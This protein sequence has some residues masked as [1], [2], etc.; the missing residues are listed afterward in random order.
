[1]LVESTDTLHCSAAAATTA[2]AP[3]ADDLPQSATAA[4][5][6]IGQSTADM[7]ACAPLCTDR[8]LTNRFV[9]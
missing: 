2:A 4:A 7:A 6:D 1:M 9:G 5:A 8:S 3:Q